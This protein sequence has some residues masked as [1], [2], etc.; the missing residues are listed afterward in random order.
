MFPLARDWVEV[1]QSLSKGSFYFVISF[2][3]INLFILF[4]FGCVGSSLLRAGFLQLQ[5]AG[6]TLSCGAQA[7]HCSSFSCCGAQALGTRASVV[8]AG[9]LSSCGPRALERRV[10]SCGAWAQLLRGLWDL[11]GPG[12]EP[13]SPALAGGFLT[14]APPGKPYYYFFNLA[15]PHSRWDLSSPTRD[16]TCVPCIGRAES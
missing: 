14:T 4:I 13:V 11:P 1:M 10:S 15:A 6:A 5:R 7:S 9:G 12:H 8:V 3:K 2:F 16:L